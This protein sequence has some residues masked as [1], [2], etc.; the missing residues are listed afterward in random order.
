VF[1][2][3]SSYGTTGAGDT[4]RVGQLRG[5]VDEVKGMMVDN[6]DKLNQRGENLDNLDE[7]TSKTQGCILSDFNTPHRNTGTRC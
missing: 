6:I 5:Q 1:V 2:C 4:S 7:R 3:R